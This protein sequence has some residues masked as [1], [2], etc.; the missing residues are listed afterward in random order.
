MN[1]YFPSSM[2]VSPC[3]R[4]KEINIG[5]KFVVDKIKN[6]DEKHVFSQRQ[7][8][9]FHLCLLKLFLVTFQKTSGKHERNISFGLPIKCPREVL[10]LEASKKA[11][12]DVG[13]MQEI[14]NKMPPFTV[15]FWGRD[16]Y[17]DYYDIRRENL[18]EKLRKKTFKRVAT[19]SKCFIVVVVYIMWAIFVP[20]SRGLS[21]ILTHHPTNLTRT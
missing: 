7:T 6:L 17:I 15:H 13:V 1:K 3:R 4:M 12:M 5:V 10:I 2:C 14:L 8:N 18:S 20:Y 9:F 16:I 19:A 11:K 21:D